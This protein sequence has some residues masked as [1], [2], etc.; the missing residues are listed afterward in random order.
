MQNEKQ[1]SVYR[2]GD[3][4]AVNPPEGPTFYIAYAE[5]VKLKRIL[6]DMEKDFSRHREFADSQI[7]PRTINARAS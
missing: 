7:S 5:A 6:S 4:V 2:F 1:C 3:Y